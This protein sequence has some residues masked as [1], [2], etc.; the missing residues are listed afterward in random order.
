LYG[1]GSGATRN[2]T[3]TI[4]DFSRGNLTGDPLFTNRSADDY[5]LLA[6]SAASDRSIL[7]WSHRVD[8]DWLTR[9]LGLAPDLGAYER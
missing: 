9:P 1:N 3:G 6:G 8:R 2:T 4:V 7:E 5:H